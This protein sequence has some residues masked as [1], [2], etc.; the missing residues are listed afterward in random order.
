MLFYIPYQPLPLL[1]LSYIKIPKS[2]L[3]GAANKF[4]QWINYSS[5]LLVSAGS[6]NILFLSLLFLGLKCW[7]MCY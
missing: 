3:I 4:L 7:V 6:D 2:V 1:S 5:V